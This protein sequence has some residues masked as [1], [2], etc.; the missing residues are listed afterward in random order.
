MVRRHPGFLVVIAALCLANTACGS[1]HKAPAS[2][3]PKRA[4]DFDTRLEFIL[5]GQELTIVLS[6]HSPEALRRRLE[7]NSFEAFCRTTHGP[8]FSPQ[9]PTLARGTGRLAPGAS[10][11]AVDLSRDVSSDVLYCG[12]EEASREDLS[13]GYFRGEGT[14]E[15]PIE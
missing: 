9:D 5:V 2:S 4:V 13:F 7:R 11:T 12:L 15:N 10:R 14:R 6:P 1:V 8:A 3:P